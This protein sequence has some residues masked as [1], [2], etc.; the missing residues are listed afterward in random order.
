LIEEV[1]PALPANV[2]YVVI[3]DGP[4]R[5]RLAALA[6]N[7][8]RVHLTGSL[9]NADLE[10]IVAA[11]DLFV[12]PNVPV[13]DDP[14]GYGIAPAEAAALGVPVLVADLEGLSDMAADHG[15]R[16]VPSADASAWAT[17]I[18]R[19]LADPDWARPTLPPRTWDIAAAE[20]ARIF[21][22]SELEA[23]VVTRASRLRGAGPVR[24]ARRARR[25]RLASASRPSSWASAR[26]KAMSMPGASSNEGPAA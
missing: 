5:D 4:D 23:S 25:A 26:S 20:Y 9:P 11:A 19:A 18:R 10:R 6:A 13:P 7:D 14:E 16:T 1:L 8:P 24:A 22:G 3:G 15:V 12:A 2:R 17:S 21:A